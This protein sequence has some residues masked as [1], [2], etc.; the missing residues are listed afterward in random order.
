M[1]AAMA[2]RLHPRSRRRR[3][4]PDPFEGRGGRGSDRSHGGDG[5]RG[6]GRSRRGTGPLADDAACTEAYG[7][8]DG[9]MA[10]LS[11]ATVVADTSTVGPW[12]SRRLNALVGERDAGML[13]A[14]VSGSVSWSSE[15]N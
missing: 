11:A 14:P 5:P 6:R 15:A 1:G 8:E 3:P 9:I 2:A 7:G 10:G 12:T 13:D 4:Q